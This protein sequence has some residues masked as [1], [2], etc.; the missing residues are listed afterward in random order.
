MGMFSFRD[1]YK[2]SPKSSSPASTNNGVSHGVVKKIYLDFGNQSNGR[3]IMPGAI[4]VETIG[5]NMSNTIIAYPYDEHFVDLPLTGEY[6]DIIYNGTTPMYRRFNFNKTINNS[7]VAAGTGQS[8]PSTG[9]GAFK[10]LGGALGALA[11][12][13][14]GGLGDYF[15]KQK[16]H[17]LKIF[18][19]DTL[20]QS[21]HGQSI[22]FSGYNNKGNNFAPTI[23]IRNRESAKNS[24][25]PESM[26]ISEDINND[27]STILLSSGEKNN[28]KFIPGTPDLLGGSDFKLRPDKSGKFIFSGLKDDQAFEAYPKKYDGEQCFITSDRLVFSSRKNE[29][30]FWSKGNYGVIT[31]GIF[32]IDTELGVNINSKGNVDIQ[33]Y[34]KKVNIYIGDSGEINLG[35]KNLKP[36][37]DGLLLT[38]ILADLIAE[39]INLKNGGLL[40]PSGPTSGMNSGLESRLELLAKKLDSTVSRY[41][42]FQF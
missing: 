40:T 36:A 29:M 20:I 18:E 30:I 27:G 23:T 25:L 2:V 28:I 15:E 10:S 12:I 37:V 14:G 1:D 22:R 32:T 42:K 16:I 4:E 21:R 17:R 39:V 26:T 38:E 11:A 31:D 19:G 34:D 13:G 7:Q 8:N 24:L 3:T 5:K 6:V 41:V 33:A 35:N 9:L